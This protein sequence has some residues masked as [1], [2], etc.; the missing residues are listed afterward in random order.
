MSKTHRPSRLAWNVLDFFASKPAW[1]ESSFR[2]S[3]PGMENDRLL[4]ISV[5]FHIYIPEGGPYSRGLYQLHICT[6]THIY[7]W[8][9]V[10]LPLWKIWLRQLGWRSF[11]TEWKVIKAMFQTTNQ[12]TMVIILT[13]ILDGHKLAWKK[14]AHFQTQLPDFGRNWEVNGRYWDFN[15][16]HGIEDGLSGS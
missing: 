15:R 7:I 4:V 9:V 13:N 3:R 5:I 11:P 6:Y 1:K 10:D 2:S 14:G 12:N 8:L 16:V